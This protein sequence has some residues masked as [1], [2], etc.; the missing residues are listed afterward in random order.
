MWR[1]GN[2]QRTPRGTHPAKQTRQFGAWRV[3]KPVR[4]RPPAFNVQ[5]GRKRADMS[6][7]IDVE[8]GDEFLHLDL[9]YQIRGNNWRNVYIGSKSTWFPTPTRSG[10]VIPTDQA[11]AILTAYGYTIT[12]PAPAVDAVPW[13]EWCAVNGDGSI[14]ALGTKEQCEKWSRFFS[15]HYTIKPLSLPPLHPTEVAAWE[16]LLRLASGLVSNWNGA[17]C[18]ND[19]S[20]KLANAINEMLQAKRGAK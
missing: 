1:E 10:T 19:R 20:A 12:T 7:V 9:M 15:S 8:A 14:L 5:P 11:R 4:F 3:A 2:T 17:A 18:V 16:A 13:P 6:K